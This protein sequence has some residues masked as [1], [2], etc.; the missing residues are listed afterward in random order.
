MRSLIVMMMFAASL[1]YAAWNGYTE[2]RE[3]ELDAEGVSE[4]EIEAGA[5][6]LVVTGDDSLDTIRV[7]ATIHVPDEDEDDAVDVIEKSLRLSLD[8]RDDKARLEG[9]F[10]DQGWNWFSDSPWVDLDVR[11]PHGITLDVDDG[12]GSIKVL[13]V[14]SDVVVD[15]GSGSITIDGVTS[16]YVD[17][18]SGSI[19]IANVTGDV[20]IDDGSGS[21]TVEHVGGSVRVDDGSG[22][23]RVD[24]VEHDLIIVDD[25]SGGLNASNVRGDIEN[26]S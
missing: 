14:H 26:D 5:G 1:T 10:E 4:F 16:V 7:T 21:I 13:R 22:S 9:W 19:D 18:G 20:E 3:L 12:S 2:D 25:G 6:A 24:D 17:D 23:I 15:D 11:V 8:R